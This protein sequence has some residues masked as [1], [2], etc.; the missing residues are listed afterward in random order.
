MTPK[1]VMGSRCSSA[2]SVCP[3]RLNSASSRRRRVGSARARKTASTRPSIRDRLVTC[4]GGWDRATPR[5]E[6]YLRLSVEAPDIHYTQTPD[7]VSIAYA[8]VG[9]GPLDLLCIPGFVSHLEVLFEAPTADRYFGR[10]AS[11]ARLLIYDR[12]GQG[13]SDRPPEP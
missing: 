7:G 3:S 1:R 8:I 5:V 2:L 4:Q 6:D 13:L 11:F 12:R 9:D 10:L